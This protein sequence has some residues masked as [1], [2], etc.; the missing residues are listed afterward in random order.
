MLFLVLEAQERF[1]FVDYDNR[2]GTH[3]GVHDNTPLAS[4]L[5]QQ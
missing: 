3:L 1:D 4:C 5:G 2:G